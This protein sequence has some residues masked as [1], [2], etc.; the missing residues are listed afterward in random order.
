MNALKRAQF[1]TVKRAVLLPAV[2]LLT[3][4]SRA[5]PLPEIPVWAFFDSDGSARI[6][7]EV[8]PR[9]FE[10]EPEKELYM[11]YW[12]LQRCDGEEKKEMLEAAKKFIPTRVAML[13]DSPEGI[14]RPTFTCSFTKLGGDPLKKMDD[15]VV[16]RAVWETKLPES[17]R[18]YQVK[19]K[20]VG[21][22]SVLFLNHIDDSA[23]PRIQTLFPGEE[24]YVLELP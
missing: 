17:T 14:P 10:E 23:I 15:P 5:H 1:F 8:D 7:I 4:L 12:Y 21:I 11:L 19:A 24:S 16:I 3:S 20:G 22:F 13:F 2:I 18:T 6:E 9:C